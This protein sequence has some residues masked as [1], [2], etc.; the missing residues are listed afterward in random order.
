MN[1]IFESPAYDCGRHLKSCGPKVREI[2]WTT[3]E[4]WDNTPAPSTAPGGGVY[5]Y[6]AYVML[7]ELGHL[8][9]LPDF[10]NE[11]DLKNV[12]AIMNRHWEAKTI[13]TDEDIAQLYAIYARHERH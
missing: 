4:S 6:V 11:R 2:V 13:K 1:V 5:V 12:T 3:V 9:G 10:Y 8:F 7:H